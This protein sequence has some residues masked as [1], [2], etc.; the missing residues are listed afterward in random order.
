[1]STPPPTQLS[2][3]QPPLSTKERLARALI[4]ESKGRYDPRIE[5]M[6]KLARAGHYDEFE[7]DIAF[8]LRTLVADLRALG[9]GAFAQR[10]IDG[11]FDAND[12]EAESWMTREGYPLLLADLERMAAEKK[13]GKP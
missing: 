7:T 1:M 13:A 2:P 5:R 10:V 11:E 9:W 3:P 8:P 12:E 6:V 4:E